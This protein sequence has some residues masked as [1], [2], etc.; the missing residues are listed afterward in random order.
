MCLGPATLP[1][2]EKAKFYIKAIRIV[3]AFQAIVVVLNFIA[4]AAFVR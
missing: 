3:L 2:T 1:P 4:A